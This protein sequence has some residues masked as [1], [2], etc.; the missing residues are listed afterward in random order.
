MMRHLMKLV[1][2]RKSRNMMLMLEIMVA[3]ILVFAISA[4]AL[5]NYELYELPTGFRYGDVWAVTIHAGK[6]SKDEFDVATY[7]KFKRGLEAMPEVEQVA[8]ASSAPYSLRSTRLDVKLPDGGPGAQTSLLEASDDYQRVAGIALDEG[9]WFGPLDDGAAATPIVINRRLAR[10]LFGSEPALGRDVV[11]SGP[12]SEN[13][14][15]LKIVGIVAEY[16]HAGELASPK[17][18]AI[19]RFVP[20]LTED[21]ARFAVIK[22]AP[23][24]TRAFEATLNQRLH[25]IRNDW[26]YTIAP[27]SAMRG[28]ILKNQTAPLVVLSVIAAFMLAM[29][30][31]GLFGVLWQNTTQRIPEIGLR[32]AIGASAA[33]IY[34]QIIAEQALLS[35]AAMAAGLLLLVQLPLTG[36]LG[37]SLGWPV[38]L[39]AAAVSMSVIYLLSLLCSVY[40]GWRASRLTPTEALHY[41]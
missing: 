14:Y 17:S 37:E 11:F 19:M 8:F 41:E 9:R 25:L 4:F 36:A 23:G 38:V 3:F 40:P 5:R 22:L 27:L 31:F 16:R 29:V 2:K 12:E 6:A 39:G 30:A 33:S 7:D 34:R 32:R 13:P 21:G 10:E 20:G 24:T 15:R 1:W 35:S 26:S 28:A 18:A